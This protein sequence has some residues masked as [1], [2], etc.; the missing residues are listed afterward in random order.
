MSLTKAS[1][2]MITG[3]PVNVLDFG[4]KGDG[5]TNDRAAIQS[6]IDAAAA[7][8]PSY[9]AVY[10]PDGAYLCSNLK[11]KHGVKLFG[12]SVDSCVI[13]VTDTTNPCIDVENYTEI[14]NIK[15]YYP[16]QVTNAA[17]TTYPATITSTTSASYVNL[18]NLQ[19]QGAW[20]FIVFGD[21]TVSV[22]PLFISNITGFPLNQGIVLDNTIDIPYISNVHF[23]PNIFGGYG[24]TLLAWVYTYGIALN[25]LRADGP[26]INNFHCFGY[27]NGVRTSVGN[28]SG[29]ANM[30]LFDNCLFDVCNQP[31]NLVNYQYGMFFSNCVFTTGGASYQG[32]TGGI[33]FV[34]TDNNVVQAIASFSNCSFRTYNSSIFNITTNCEFVNCQ[35]DDYNQVV[36]SYAAVNL[37]Y[38]GI[39][40]KFTAC[41]FDTR[42]RA[43]TQGIVS[44]STT[45]NLVLQGNSFVNFTGSNPV[46]IKGYLFA[47]SNNLNGTVYTWN[48]VVCQDVSG[49]L[50][51]YQ[52]P[53]SFTVTAPFNKGAYFGNY[54]PAV[55]QPK[56]WICTVSGT[57]GT[58]VSTG[59]L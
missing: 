26:K 49:V 33:N 24:S 17:P 44:N 56:A 13:Y 27:K 57:P 1:Y 32:V 53:T 43:N 7:T 12:N 34:G 51:T 20:N 59:N 42:S 31:I 3:A 16:Q 21:N 5:V 15:F 29:S 46:S 11:L 54:D 18:N 40:V 30:A 35:F 39:E 6:A 4:A 58:W 28:P 37:A 2:S 9:A 10:L 23:N 8:L 22:G 45:T 41:Y 50:M 25:F 14:S 55:G 47:S 38:S 19:V 52:I 36:G 48:G